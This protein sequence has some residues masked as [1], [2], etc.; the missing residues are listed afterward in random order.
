MS[1][2]AVTAEE[3]QRP[4]VPYRDAL[5]QIVGAFAALEP[6]D[7]AV[8]DA[9]G[10]VTPEPIIAPIDVPGFANSAMDGYAI[11]SRDTSEPP[12]V[13]RLVD[14]LPAGSDPTID[15]APGTAAT[16]M[17]GAPLPPGADAVVPWEDTERR[18]GEVAVLVKIPPG[19]HV[20]PAGE[21]VQAGSVVLE[22][23]TE[24]RPIHIGVLASLGLAQVLVIRR[25][26][27]A[28]L[29][30][31]DELAAPGEALKPGHVYDSNRAL[32]AAMCA[33]A[34]ADVVAS[35]LIGDEPD[36]IAAWLRDAARTA[37]LIVTT[38]GASVG[39]HDWI[40]AILESEGDLALWRIAIKPGKPVAF[41]RI[42][43]TPVLGLPGNPGSA[44]VG[45]HVFVAR[46]IRTMAG[47]A[48]EPSS[49]RARLGAAVKG[50]P[51]RTMFCRVRL[52]GDIAVPLPAQSSVVLSN[53]IPADGF[54]IVPPG[55]LPEG[56]EVTVELI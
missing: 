49:V 9:L 52:D 56:T 17:T 43:G 12:V 3:L 33:R 8:E 48:V 5:A 7:V 24:L 27:V 20:R 35:A 15:I 26:Y 14:D 25:P 19:K 51:S 46:A 18:D 34:G 31:G 1:K 45:M 40:R 39:E 21:D 37:D 11:N 50:S 2:R 4:L 6:V 28:I 53:I 32:L 47:R 16:I 30:T 13:L 38:G 55:G 54:A 23:G 41:G 44:F 36:A 42:D 10:L 29:S 22:A